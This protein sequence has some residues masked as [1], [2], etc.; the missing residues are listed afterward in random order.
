MD[1][2]LSDKEIER[3]LKEKKPLPKDYHQKI[4]VRPKRGHKE[5]ELDVKGA[6][7][8]DF[9]IILRQSFFNTLDF[10][11]ILS[12]RPVNSNH[13]FRLRRYNGKSHQHTNTV[14]GN[15]FYDFHIHQAS[16]RYQI[17]GAREDAFAEPTN[18]F[19][20]FHEAISCMIKN[21]GFDAPVD[22]QR[23]LFEEKEP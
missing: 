5:S 20:D 11:I 6:E 8:N 1:N 2:V 23:K 16:E 12:Y 14:E 7:G 19:S 15:T 3:L 18:K 4:K 10:S 22:P 9:R 13:L 21:C 17:I